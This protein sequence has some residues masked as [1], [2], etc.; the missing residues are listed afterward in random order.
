M[1]QTSYKTDYKK[2]VLKSQGVTLPSEKPYSLCR[3]IYLI[4]SMGS[5]DDETLNNRF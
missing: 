2:R 3:V 1:Y 5:Y 4:L